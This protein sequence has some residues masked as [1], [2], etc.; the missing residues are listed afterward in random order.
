MVWT[1]FKNRNQ[2]QVCEGCL[3]SFNSKETLEVHEEFCVDDGVKAVLPPPRSVVKFRKVQ[4]CTVVPFVIYADFES[5]LEK[6]SKLVGEKTTQIQHH[7]PLQL[8]FSSCFKSWRGIFSNVFPRKKEDDV[9]KYFW[10]CWL[11]KLNGF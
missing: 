4:C 11:K 5:I 2:R 6:T 10:K 7:I 3:N 8:L 1:R 9:G